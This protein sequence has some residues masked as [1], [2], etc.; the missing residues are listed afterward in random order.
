[1]PV[2]KVLVV[3]S[4]WITT[5][6]G[7]D[8]HRFRSALSHAAR[9][10][11]AEARRA[12]ANRYLCTEVQ[13]FGDL[14]KVLGPENVFIVG[15]YYPEYEWNRL[16]ADTR[17]PSLHKTPAGTHVPPEEA[18]ALVRRVDAVVVGARSRGLGEAVRRE[19]RRTDVPI[20]LLDYFDHLEV[21]DD[22]RP[23]IVTRGLERGRDY[24]VYFKH[25]L[26]IGM[27]S[28]ALCPL[29]P[30][31]VRAESFPGRLDPFTARDIAVFY[32]GQKR[33]GVLR[34]DRTA[35]ADAMA[36][37]PGAVIDNQE[38]L[39]SETL[40]GYWAKLQRTKVA[41]SPAGKV[42][43][44]T[45]HCEAAMFGCAPL[46][47]EPDCE[48]VGRAGFSD[49]HALRYKARRLGAGAYDIEDVQGIVEKVTHYLNNTEKL[50]RV[51]GQ[52]RDEVI[53]HHT[54]EAR[55]RYLVQQLERSLS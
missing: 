35:I 49:A 18:V 32:R 41:L 46:M 15:R 8:N 3:P 4:E 9:G 50:A 6:S 44:S 40:E 36:A 29:A 48:T 25:D 38:R 33:P 55:A 54:T 2:K 31:P 47:P 14:P 12:W 1:V 11:L 5:Y 16:P 26:P 10:R 23:T 34:S 22:P 30:M 13:H 37:I 43:D 28:E 21:Y 24:S 39:A 19:A 7:R 53:A 52:W 42:W 45:R 17:Y 20:A 51:A 27:A